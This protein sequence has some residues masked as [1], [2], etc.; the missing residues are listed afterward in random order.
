MTD[1]M[2]PY[3]EVVENTVGKDWVIGDVH[4]QYNLLM[5]RLRSVGYN[6]RTDRLFFVGDL[7]DYGPK[8]RCV[9][10]LTNHSNIFAVKGNHELLALAA[11]RGSRNLR[12]WVKRGGRW[13]NNHG[14]STVEMIR[15]EIR[16]LPSAITIPYQGKRIGIVHAYPPKVWGDSL[17]EEHI[18]S[19]QR[20]KEGIATEVENVD[21]VAVGH[22]IVDEI[23]VLGNVVH[24]DLGAKNRNNL[25]VVSLDELLGYL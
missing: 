9:I 23:T 11:E 2:H 8:S 1:L 25:A 10:G 16:A 22:C 19:R 5:S 4:G 6:A 12:K 3:L 13:I 7:I 20:L 17:T 14:R 15:K 24:L 18:T 21:V